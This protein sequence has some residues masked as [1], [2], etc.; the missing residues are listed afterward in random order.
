MKVYVAGAT[1]A[2]GSRLV[3]ILVRAAHQVIG[4]T[5]TP[6]KAAAI[7]AAD[8]EAVVMDAL[9]PSAVMQATQAAKP[10]VVVHQLTAIPANL[11]M[12]KFDCDFSMTIR[13]RTEV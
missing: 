10:D 2:I 13:L 4:A 12:R 9:N 7:H 1:G 3:P 5:R 8:G 11:N 6:A